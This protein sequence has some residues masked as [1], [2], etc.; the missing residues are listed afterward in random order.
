MYNFVMKIINEVKMLAAK[1]G[2]TLT[3]IAKY[4]DE[5]SNKNYNIDSLSKKL[6]SETLKY[7]EMKLIAEA[8]NLEIE[9]KDKI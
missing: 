7:T 8:L 3:Y 5:H 1:Q 4:L 9:F 6:R 2:K